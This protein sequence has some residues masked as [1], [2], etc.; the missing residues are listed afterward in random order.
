[1]KKILVL[2]SFIAVSLGAHAQVEQWTVKFVDPLNGTQQ[3]VLV[4]KMITNFNFSCAPQSITVFSS[5]CQVKMPKPCMTET[6][7][8]RVVN[9]TL[10]DCRCS[11][12][13]ASVTVTQITGLKK[14]G[15]V[16]KG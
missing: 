16:V 12:T 1:M 14:K 11:A 13:I 7:L 3:G 10:D 2:L 4:N 6:E 9:K 8:R 15:K 5:G